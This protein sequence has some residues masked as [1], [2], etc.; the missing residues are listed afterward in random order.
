MI[1]VIT[2]NI[3]QLIS[4]VMFDIRELTKDISI[5]VKVKKDTLE[6]D[7]DGQPFKIKLALPDVENNRDIQLSCLVA[8]WYRGFPI[9][10]FDAIGDKL[11]PLAEQLVA[12][13]VPNISLS[14][15]GINN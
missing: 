11:K 10:A 2:E 1:H 15:S 12:V 13:S 7:V 3:K 9:A 4:D 6:F 14:D 5:T 8:L